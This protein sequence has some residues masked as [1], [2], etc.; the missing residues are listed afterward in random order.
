MAARESVAVIAATNRETAAT[1]RETATTKAVA[2]T[3][4]EE[5][6]NAAGNPKTTVSHNKTVKS[7]FY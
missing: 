6:A 7:P 4:T 2:V 3:T 1:T 5:T